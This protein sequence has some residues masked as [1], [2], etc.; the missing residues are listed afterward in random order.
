MPP[1][2]TKR[3]LVL[4]S[5][6]SPANPIADLGLT[7]EAS[8]T[9]AA[10]VAAANLFEDLSIVGN[11]SSKYKMTFT[12]TSAVVGELTCSFAGRGENLAS[13]V[14]VA[15]TSVVST[16]VPRETATTVTLLPSPDAHFTRT[17]QQN[18][19]SSGTTLVKQ[20]G[21]LDVRVKA[22]SGYFVTQTVTS[23]AAAALVLTYTWADGFGNPVVSGTVR[24]DALATALGSY[25]LGSATVVDA[26]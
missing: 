18:A 25:T 17:W 12:L 10:G 8:F 23:N 3:V 6:Y 14:S 1:P 11:E 22:G 5:G 19:L 4:Q 9:V 20:V 15:K 21:Y 26:Q 2:K 13:G 7:M 16:F 24:L